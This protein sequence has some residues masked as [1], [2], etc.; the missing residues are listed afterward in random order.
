MFL[1]YDLGFFCIFAPNDIDNAK[2]MAMMM[3][4]QYINC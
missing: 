2:L 3:W 1:A 4:K